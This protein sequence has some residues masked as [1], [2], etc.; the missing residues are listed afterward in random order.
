MIKL[1]KPNILNRD[2]LN[3]VKVVKSGNLVQGKFVNLFEKEISRYIGV[4]HS[5]LV[6]SGTAALH[7]SLLALNIKRDDE[8]IAPAF[9]FPATTNVIEVIEANTVLVDINLSDF[10]IDVN[11]IEEKITNKTKAIIVVHEFGQSAE[12]DKIVNIAQ[13]NNL[14]LIEDAACALG[15]EFNNKK[16]GTFGKLGCFSLHPRKAVTTGEGGIVV[17]NDD[18]L[19]KKI[20]SLLNHGI[21]RKGEKV[22]FIFAGLNYRLTDF[23]AALCINQFKSLD[24]SNIFREEIVKKY[25]E[26][27]KNNKYISLPSFLNDRKS[28]W[29]TYYLILDKKVDRD[30]MISKLKK[31]GIETNYGAYAINTLSYYKKKYRFNNSEYQ[32]SFIAFKQGLALPIGKHV[33]KKEINFIVSKINSV[34][35]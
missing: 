26:G 15:A 6:S 2:I 10:C 12:M 5:I 11:K 27:L 24:K 1:S 29:Q 30:K 23:Q 22:D 14:I 3:L 16:V 4:K 21:E 7:L 25:N 9:T 13:K 31:Y 8:I 28:S 17:T 33:G 32:N 35:N 18:L 19:A 34:I 20:R